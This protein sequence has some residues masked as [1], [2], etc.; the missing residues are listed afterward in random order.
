ML[1]HCFSTFILHSLKRYK[2]KSDII[3][4]KLYFLVEGKWSKLKVLN[5]HKTQ[6]TKKKTL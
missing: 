2:N 6:H 1:L 3:S 4:Q 5:S